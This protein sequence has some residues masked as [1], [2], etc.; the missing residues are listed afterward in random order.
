MS[1]ACGITVLFF[2]RCRPR[3]RLVRAIPTL[4]QFQARSNQTTTSTTTTPTSSTLRAWADML[5]EAG[6]GAGLVRVPN[7][8]A[9]AEYTRH[10]LKTVMEMSEFSRGEGEG[11]TDQSRHQ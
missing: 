2:N 4:G 1:P 11:Q 9:D 10:R 3:A 7:P 8:E 6:T 5:E